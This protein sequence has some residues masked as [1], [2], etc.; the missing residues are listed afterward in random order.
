MCGTAIPPTWTPLP[1][2]FPLGLKAY[3]QLAFPHKP[4]FR[5][6]QRILRVADCIFT[7]VEVAALRI[8]TQLKA[9]L[10]RIS[11]HIATQ[12]QDVVL[13]ILIKLQI[14]VSHLPWWNISCFWT[15]ILLR[16]YDAI[17]AVSR[18]IKQIVT[19][20]LLILSTWVGTVLKIRVPQYSV[21]KRRHLDEEPTENHRYPPNHFHAHWLQSSGSKRGTLRVDNK[22]LIHHVCVCDWM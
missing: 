10:L 21:F 20:F 3:P 15:E 8:S 9:V 12:L 13:C 22:A 6:F 18:I 2:R 1:T 19:V 7:H 5:A 14:V 16:K 11:T 4:R 17:F